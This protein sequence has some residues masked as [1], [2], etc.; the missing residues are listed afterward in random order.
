[1]SSIDVWFALSDDSTAAAALSNNKIK[2]SLYMNDFATAQERSLQI[3][4]S[5]LQADGY[6]GNPVS[7]YHKITMNP[8]DFGIAG[9]NVFMRVYVKDPQNDITEIPSKYSES[10]F[11]AYFTLVLEK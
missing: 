5:P 11:K 8:Y 2:F 6:E 10:I 9:N 4:S 1:M 7:Y 3:L